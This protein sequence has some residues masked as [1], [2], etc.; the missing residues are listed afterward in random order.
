MGYYIKDL[1]NCLMPQG[2]PYTELY[3]FFNVL[4][5]D[6][7]QTKGTVRHECLQ[8]C[9]MKFERDKLSKRLWYQT[10]RP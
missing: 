2:E 5:K 4:Y 3:A 9:G 6:K 10:D 8:V 7:K 1:F